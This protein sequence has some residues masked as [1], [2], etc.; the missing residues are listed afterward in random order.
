MRMNFH[1]AA[2]VALAGWYL[3]MPPI[4]SVE[5]RRNPATGSYVAY[6]THPLD[7]WELLGSYNSAAACAKALDQAN[8]LVKQDCAECSVVASCVASDDARLKAKE[9]LQ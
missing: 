2:T 3:M 5:S 9:N 1:H 8:R 7:T 6:S 4:G